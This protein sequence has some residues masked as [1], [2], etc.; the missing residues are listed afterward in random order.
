MAVGLHFWIW[1]MLRTQIPD[2]DGEGKE[3]R[4]SW[5]QGEEAVG[6]L[7]LEQRE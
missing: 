1:E 7:T 6:G 2:P 4:D 3:N 5:I